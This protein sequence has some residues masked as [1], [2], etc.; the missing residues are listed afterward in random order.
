[1]YFDLLLGLF[2]GGL[3]LTKLLTETQSFIKHTQAHKPAND[4]REKMGHKCAQQN[5]GNHLTILQ[6]YFIWMNRLQN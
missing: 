6:G 4:R 3:L 5:K 1:M 2:Y